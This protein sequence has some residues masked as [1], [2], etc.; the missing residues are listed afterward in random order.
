VT[1]GGD[2]WR[3]CTNATGHAD[4]D[5]VTVTGR[6]SWARHPAPPLGRRW[7]A[8]RRRHV[9]DAGSIACGRDVPTTMVLSACAPA[10]S[11]SPSTAPR[12]AAPL[13]PAVPQV[14]TITCADRAVP[15]LHA[16][17]V[18]RAATGLGMP[19]ST[20]RGDGRRQAPQFRRARRR[21]PLHPDRAG[22][23]RP[24]VGARLPPRRGGHGVGSSA[25][26]RPGA[27]QDRAAIRPP[28]PTRRHRGP[29]RRRRHTLAGDE[30]VLSNVL[31][32]CQ[33][34]A[35]VPTQHI[36]AAPKLF[37]R[38]RALPASRSTSRRCRRC[39]VIPSST[40]TTSSAPLPTAGGGI[41]RPP[42]RLLDRLPPR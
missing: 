5:K 24:L 7:R 17:G 35:H 4:G 1:G 36:Q 27:R 21:E 6:W 39:P 8:V 14:L 38:Q 28:A 29:G 19:R 31:Q 23:P 42:C 41:A 12:P 13:V 25:R 3:V 33:R 15:Q 9:P 2:R 10:R 18:G 37:D 26:R 40:A 34:D 22:W 11:T 32:R 30:R 16:A 20:A